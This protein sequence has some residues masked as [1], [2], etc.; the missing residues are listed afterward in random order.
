M[1]GANYYPPK[2]FSVF[3]N[4][5]ILT[6]ELVGDVMEQMVNFSGQYTKPDNP[7]F[8]RSSFRACHLE[9]FVRTYAADIVPDIATVGIKET[10]CEEYIPYFLDCEW[11]VLVVIRDPR[12]VVASLDSGRG[13]H[14]RGRAKPLLFNLRTWRKSAAMILNFSDRENFHWIKYEDLVTDPV[15]GFAS[16]TKFLGLE[17]IPEDLLSGE[18]YDQSGK[19][20]RSNSSG[21]TTTRITS[22]NV[23]SYRSILRPVDQTFIQALCMPELAA[24]GYPIELS[25]SAVPDI[26]NGYQVNPLWLWQWL[27]LGVLESFTDFCPFKNKSTKFSK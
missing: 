8:W 25:A 13:R 11:K 15:T 10:F 18:L 26:L 9:E 12:A 1:I 17:P 27:V 3:L 5:Y 4:Q 2:E 19:I 23:D 7:L 21:A 16:V 22:S 14:Y 6:D 24:L 20:W